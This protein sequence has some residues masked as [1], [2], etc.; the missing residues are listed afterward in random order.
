MAAYAYKNSKGNTYYLH[1]RSTTLR[2]GKEQR[3]YFFAREEKEGTLDKVPEGYAV[4][5]TANGL[6]VLKRSD[7]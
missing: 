1:S 6:P 2:N 5:E 7:R 4:S 3:I